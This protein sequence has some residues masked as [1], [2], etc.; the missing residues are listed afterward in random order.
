[1]QSSQVRTSPLLRN[2]ATR[3][4]DTRIQVTTKLGSQTV[5]RA[6][7]IPSL[8]PSEANLQHDFLMDLALRANP[9]AIGILKDMADRC[10]DDQATAVREIL[11]DASGTQLSN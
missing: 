2:F 10:I 5:V 3:L 7:F 9:G 6:D 8:F 1:M 4:D 11:D